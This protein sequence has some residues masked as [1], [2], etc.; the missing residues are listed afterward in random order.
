MADST[1]L[2]VHFDTNDRPFWL[3]FAQ[4]I[5]HFKNVPFDLF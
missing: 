4:A 3:N 2:I 5:V 1:V